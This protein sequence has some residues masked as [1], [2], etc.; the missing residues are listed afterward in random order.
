VEFIC[1]NSCPT[2]HTA[3]RDKLLA[4]AIG[5]LGQ[6]MASLRAASWGDRC[7]LPATSKPP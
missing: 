4:A 2:F 1:P 5:S 7:A 6:S 3:T